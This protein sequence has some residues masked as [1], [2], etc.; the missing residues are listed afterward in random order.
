MH[1]NGK[2]PTSEPTASPRSPEKAFASRLAEEQG[3]LTKVMRD[4]CS[5]CRLLDGH[6]RLG[7]EE[8]QAVCAKVLDG[9][10]AHGFVKPDE[11]I[12]IPDILCKRIDDAMMETMDRVNA[13][14]I[15][16]RQL[17]AESLV[18]AGT[19]IFTT[20]NIALV[21]TDPDGQAE[22]NKTIS[23]AVQVVRKAL[24][25]INSQSLYLAHIDI[26]GELVGMKI[27][28]GK[29]KGYICVFCPEGEDAA[30]VYFKHFEHGQ[31]K[32]SDNRVKFV[33]EA[34]T[35]YGL[36]SSVS[37]RGMDSCD[38]RTIQFTAASQ[39]EPVLETVVRLSRAVKDLDM[40]LSSSQQATLAAMMF[41][42]GVTNMIEFLTSFNTR[43]RPSAAPERHLALAEYEKG[44]LED[45]LDEAEKLGAWADGIRERHADIRRVKDLNFSVLKL[46]TELQFAI[47]GYTKDDRL[48]PKREIERR[49]TDICC[50]LVEMARACDGRGDS[51]EQGW[52]EQKAKE[53]ISKYDRIISACGWTLDESETAQVMG[54]FAD[55]GG[56]LEY[57][58][59]S[60]IEELVRLMHAKT[61]L[62]CGW[63][64]S[65]G[66]FRAE[67][68]RL[69]MLDCIVPLSRGFT[70]LNIEKGEEADELETYRILNS[71]LKSTSVFGEDPGFAVVGADSADISMPQGKHYVE[72]S[73]DL[74]DKNAS[75][76]LRLRYFETRYQNA[77]NR[78]AYVMGMLERLGF[79][80]SREG[81]LIEAS[82][83]T[84]DR[85][86]WAV[87]YRETVR[88]MLSVRNLDL[89]GAEP[90]HMERLFLIGFTNL[91]RCI[92]FD[93]DMTRGSDEG[94]ASLYKR[95][96][97]NSS[98]CDGDKA[99]YTRLFVELLE[100]K[101]SRIMPLLA[102]FE[103]NELD[104]LFEYLYDL[105][106]EARESGDARRARKIVA[107]EN[108][109]EKLILG[110]LPPKE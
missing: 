110:K 67:N 55:R 23:E 56:E 46:C 97:A 108:K 94:R 1:K 50:G 85:K 8:R 9:L 52:Y 95:I 98:F 41:G 29:H 84:Q 99:A 89:M 80:A 64:Q 32:F 51:D 6:G 103:V 31:G 43:Q 19:K 91:N 100:Y 71:L 82:M 57:G 13:G 11:D 45:A 78:S 49:F 16:L 63:M 105:E 92:G 87:T 73:T 60:T 76:S 18:E 72:I 86:R 36:A 83:R 65:D 69:L 21:I 54:M 104:R 66:N 74:D 40:S 48:V 2:P 90:E 33:R 102:G 20:R 5:L 12:N 24:G 77:E 28:H 17:E 22:K 88:L 4:L 101:P 15:S 34:L 10:K 26:E 109:L 30:V 107:L 79:S 58:K 3:G 59:V 61:I 93:T 53:L 27:D 47:L 68:E 44:L 42:R 38:V 96:L 7:Q 75:Y 25:W 106:C 14:E 39:L 62:P 70:C 81:S 35:K 37:R